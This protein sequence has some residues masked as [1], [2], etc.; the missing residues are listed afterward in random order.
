M[1]IR[2]SPEQTEKLFSSFCGSYCACQPWPTLPLV[3]WYEAF[4]AAERSSVCS[5]RSMKIRTI[6]CHSRDKV[7]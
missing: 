6:V 3:E 1:A 2:M 7:L 4:Q 5:T